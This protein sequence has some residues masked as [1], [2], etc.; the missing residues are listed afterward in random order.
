MHE[1][2]PKITLQVTYGL[3]IH[4][5]IQNPVK[6]LKWSRKGRLTKSSYSLE[7]FPKDITVFLIGM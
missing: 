2:E 4:R 3:Y 5:G 1:T 6:H 7:L